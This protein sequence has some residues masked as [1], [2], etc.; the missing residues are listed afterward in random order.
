MGGVRHL[1]TDLSLFHD[2]LF[3]SQPGFVVHQSLFSLKTQEVL[4]R[5]AE[6]LLE[7]NKS[8]GNGYLMPNPTEIKFDPHDL[9]Q[10]LLS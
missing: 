10:R 6:L 9:L 1:G 8:V 7:K 3:K 5:A 4:Q 2:N